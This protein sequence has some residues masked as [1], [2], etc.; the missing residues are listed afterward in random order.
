M[1]MR[2]TKADGKVP[3]ENED[4]TRFSEKKP[5][6]NLYAYFCELHLRKVCFNVNIIQ[7]LTICFATILRHKV[8]RVIPQNEDQVRSL[9][10]L[11]QRRNDVSA[12]NGSNSR[13][14][15]GYFRV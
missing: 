11:L 3:L 9:R 2:N 4:D 5:N 10:E 8:L 1:R 6:N 15:L 14:R 7:Q 13:R 12:K